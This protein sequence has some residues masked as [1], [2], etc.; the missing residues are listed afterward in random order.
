[1]RAEDSGIL[2]YRRLAAARIVAPPLGREA[3]ELDGI[4]NDR[5]GLPREWRKR[6][7][8]TLNFS[9]AGKAEQGG[10]QQSSRFDLEGEFVHSAFKGR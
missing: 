7:M 10:L 4:P 3:R 9:L 1:M 5:G 8:I 2:F 6:A